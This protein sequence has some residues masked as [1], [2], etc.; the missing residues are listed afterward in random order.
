VL[1]PRKRK[2]KDSSTISRPSKKLKVKEW[3]KE[4]CSGMFFLKTLTGKKIK[5]DAK[6][7]D[8]IEQ[9]KLKIQ[10]KEGTDLFT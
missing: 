6:Y 4:Q 8:T 10:Q 9:I 5:I 1:N 3:L 2:N 7:S